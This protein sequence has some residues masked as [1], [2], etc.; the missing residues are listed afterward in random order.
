M[1]L[2]NSSNSARAL[3]IMIKIILAFCLLISTTVSSFAQRPGN[4]ENWCRNGAFPHD[5]E[6]FSIGTIKAN[7]GEPI[8]IYGDNDNC[9][10]DKNCRQKASLVTGNEVIV[11]RKFGNWACSWY[12]PNKGDETVGWIS[13]EN[14]VFA[15]FVQGTEDYAGKWKFYDNDIEIKKT[16]DPKV[17]E[18]T[19]NA[20]WKG[21]GDNVHIGEVNGK[22]VWNEKY[23]AYGEDVQVEDDCQVKLNLVRNYLIVKDNMSCGGA[24]VTFSG[25]YQKESSR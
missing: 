1:S 19:G 14:L 23:L 7:K 13:L 4:P 20:Y 12:Q 10:N 15:P 21:F 25:V 8:Y 6:S 16:K 24:N 11:S 2:K 22:A 5:S 18:I 17:F 3:K 9:P